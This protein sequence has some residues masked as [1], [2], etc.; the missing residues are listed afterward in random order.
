MTNTT[1]D[2]TMDIPTDVAQTM[3]RRRRRLGRTDFY[4]SPL[5]IGGAW[6]GRTPQG[7]DERTAVA[8]V[9]RGLDLG[10]NLIDTSPLYMRRTSERFIGLALEAWQQR[11]G[12]RE[13]LILST[14]TGHYGRDRDYSA[15]RT[16]RSVE[17]SMALLK[18]EYLDVVLVHDPVDLT[19]V[20]APDGALAALK[21]LKAQGVIRA[22]GLGVRDHAFHRRCIAT[23]DFDVSLTFRDFNLL[24]QSAV[25]GVLE[26]AA[27]H[28]VGVFNGSPLING[29]LTGEEPQALVRR[30][31][32][33]GRRWTRFEQSAIERAQALWTWAQARDIDL[34]ALNL[35]YCLREPRIAATLVG[36]STPAHIAADVAAIAT[37]LPASV[38]EGL[39]EDFGV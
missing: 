33:R 39:R 14:K 20:L 37:P 22:I 28:D 4:V 17:E 19:P 35:Q 36:P 24:D 32:A 21:D 30:A 38:W 13:D 34:L 31:E 27:V 16:Y 29:L 11:G 7:V 12:R 5:G 15:A 8:T 23:G 6:L 25:A 9:L 26:V 3:A 2:I 18:T 10:L 1:T